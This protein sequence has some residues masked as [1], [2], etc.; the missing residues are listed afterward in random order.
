MLKRRALYAAVIVMAAGLAFW[1]GSPFLAAMTALLVL[2][3]L[4]LFWLLRRDMGAVTMSLQVPASCPVGKPCP[5]TVY[6]TCPRRPWVMG[7][8]TLRIRWHNGMFDDVVEQERRLYLSDG[9]I[10][11]QVSITSDLCGAAE[12]SCLSAVGTDILGLCAGS[13]PC[14][15]P[16]SV[17]VVPTPLSLRLVPAENRLGRM[18]NELEF[19]NRRGPEFSEIFDLHPYAPGD[20]VRSIHWKLSGKLNELIVRQGSEPAHNYTAVILDA[21]LA[22]DEQTVPPQLV[23]GAVRLAAAVSS[24]LARDGVPHQNVFSARGGL[25]SHDVRSQ[26]ESADTVLQWMSFTLPQ[27]TG[28]GVRR[29]LAANAQREFA[30]IIY[31]TAGPLVPEVDSLAARRSVTA[32]CVSN[33]DRPRLTRRADCYMMELPLAALEDGKLQLPV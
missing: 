5:I 33:C 32:L 21:G 2:L 15:K 11:F 4:L 14:P 12:V 31:I 19:F 13:I 7:L 6:I 26:E 8:I 1:S 25:W 29:F 28:T 30:R 10:Q 27:Q 18:D 3:P 24:R 23:V 20:D 22:Q 16:S 9:V 17:I